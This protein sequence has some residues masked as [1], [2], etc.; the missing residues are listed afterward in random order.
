M[1]SNT[2]P[3]VDEILS[4]QLCLGNLPAATSSKL[5]K[6][7]GI[8][9][10]LSVCP[11]Y[12][13]TGDA[14]HMTVPVN[15]SEYEDLLI[16]F[17]ETCR[18]IEDALADGGKVL[19]HCVMGVSRSTT[20]VTAYLMKSRLLSSL[21]ALQ[22]IRTCRPQ[23]QPNYGFRKQLDTFADCQYSPSASHPAY[24]SW[25]RKHKQDVTNFL[26]QIVDTVTM[27]PNALFL[28][29][30]LPTEPYQAEL[31][32]Y[33]LNVTHLLTLAPADIS[34]PTTGLV[35]RHIDVSPEALEEF[36]FTL[37]DTCAFI[38][39]AIAGGGRVLVHSQVEARACTAVGAYL[40]SSQNL[41]PEKAAAAISAA[42]PLFEPTTNFKRA[43][44]LFRACKYSPTPDH[45]ALDDH[46]GN[47]GYVSW[48]SSPASSNPS[49]RRPSGFAA[50][51]ADLMIRKAAAVMTDSGI[52]MKAFGDALV[53]I[54]AKPSLTRAAA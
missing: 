53:S 37:P 42:L 18:F 6:E 15:D 22:L 10:V 20:V 38:S 27:V 1:S 35:C 11:D 51:D 39:D 21:D 23:V 54:Q 7:L 46:K 16:H 45:P 33:E 36:L 43:L 40:M 52:D 28:N 24:L 31:L 32:L 44:S 13:S 2:I 29:S 25:K 5:R 47:S 3:S 48:G 19:V 14:H 49:S 26:N 41:T 9:H 4:G 8:T 34:F 30:D 17:P 12:P 50:Q